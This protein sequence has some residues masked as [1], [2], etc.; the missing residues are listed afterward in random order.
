M[1]E[2]KERME[3]LIQVAKERDELHEHSSWWELKENLKYHATREEVEMIDRLW[4]NAEAG[5]ALE[6]WDENFLLAISGEYKTQKQRMDELSSQFYQQSLAQQVK[7]QQAQMQAQL[8]QN[9]YQNTG[10]SGLIGSLLGK[11]GGI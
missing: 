10:T 1:L 6:T 7:A 9:P 4:I 2:I 5:L 11:I 3:K 8:Q